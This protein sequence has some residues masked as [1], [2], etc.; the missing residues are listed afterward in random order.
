MRS[1]T[2]IL[3]RRHL[4][5]TVLVAPMV[6]ARLT[7]AQTAALR[8]LCAIALEA[9]VRAVADE[10]TRR[11]S[12]PVMM[13]FEVAGVV[14]RDVRGTEPLELVL[15]RTDHLR[16]FAAEGLVQAASIADLGRMVMGFAVRSGAPAPDISTPDALR[17]ALLAAPSIALSDAASGATTAI[18]A[19]EVLARLGIADAVASRI[20][21]YPT[22]RAAVRGVAQ[23]EAS[24]VM[25]FVN[26][27]GI[28]S[29]VTLVGPL[30]AP[31]ALV[32]PF[33]GGVAAR[34]AD[35]EGAAGLLALLTSPYGAER[36]RAAGFTLG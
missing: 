4:I 12:R 18:H 29:G 27:F 36:F 25:T 6:V 20:R 5:G 34:A 7:V 3:R 11:T 32:Q 23:G 16:E 10:F 21:V 17:A 8:G 31:H 19:R 24:L 22:G 13:R 15:S 35:A 14:A 33:S 28:G 1:E 9:P 26:E 30:P 2:H